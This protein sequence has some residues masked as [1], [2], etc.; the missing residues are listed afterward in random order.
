MRLLF[1]VGA[2]GLLLALGVLAGCASSATPPTCDSTCNG[3]CDGTTCVEATGD[4]ACGI[5][6]NL[7]QKCRSNETCTDGICKTTACNGCVDATTKACATGNTD[8]QCGAAGG[9]CSKCGTGTA[10]KNGVCLSTACMGCTDATMK[11][12]LG[13]TDTQCGSGGKACVACTGG[14]KCDDK[15]CVAPA[16][17]SAATCASGCCD[18]N[19]KCVDS[20]EEHCG[21][22]GG[23][24]STCSGTQTCGT[25]GTCKAPCMETCAGCCD[26][27]GNCLASMKESCGKPGADCVACA[28]TESCSEGTCI[29]ASCSAS[30]T[31][32]C[33]AGNACNT[34]TTAAACGGGGNACVTCAAGQTCV[35][36]AC[37]V[38]ANS[39]WDLVLVS[40]VVPETDSNG[41]YWDALAGRPD[42]YVKVTLDFG[43][44]G[45]VTGSSASVSDT[46]QPVWNFSIKDRTAELLMKVTYLELFDYDPIGSDQSMGLCSYMF[47]NAD[48]D[49]ALHEIT[50]PG[51]GA[52]GFAWKLTFK[53][54]PHI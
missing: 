13:I 50:C 22:S 30:C 14:Q 32:G 1:A 34:G 25:N 49:S 41:A 40:A 24:C 43:G 53:I 26:A 51:L 12:Q 38:D 16:T 17:C 18:D 46:T 29:S 3:C 10:C 2:V 33:C 4:N 9:T 52:S 11:C 35:T 19:D 47:A 44:P 28:A 20:N 45:T 6:G 15:H 37:R 48:F 8:A 7:C 21:T 23:R 42:P 36:Q 39:K 31:T 27:S 54:I 5:T